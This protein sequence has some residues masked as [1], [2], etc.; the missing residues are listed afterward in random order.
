MERLISWQAMI[1]ARK[2]AL[3]RER[4]KL[5]QSDLA[6]AAGVK[7]STVAQIENG[8]IKTS[9]HLFKMAEAMGVQAHEIDPDLPATT[10]GGFASLPVKGEVRAGNWLEVDGEPEAISYI[11]AAPDPRYAGSQQYALKVVGSSMNR[12]T[13][14][15]SFVIVADWRNGEIRNGDL[16]VVRRERGPVYEVTLKRARK[17]KKGWE[18]WPESDDP[19]YQTPLQLS[20]GEPDVAVYIVGKVIAKYEPL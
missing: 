10:E 2:F 18:L 13:P 15:G 20:D 4:S 7:Q 9:K 8:S 16:L 14:P 3:F 6:R 1:D 12:V 11:S 19:R 17:G 5:S